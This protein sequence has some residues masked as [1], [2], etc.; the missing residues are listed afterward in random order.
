MKQM[1]HLNED[2]RLHLNWSWY[3]DEPSQWNDY[4]FELLSREFQILNY[5]SDMSFILEVQEPGLFL[6]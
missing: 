1:N 2:W 4:V 3:Y 5:V 6:D